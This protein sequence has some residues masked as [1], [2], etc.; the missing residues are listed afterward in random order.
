MCHMNEEQ[1]SEVTS[2]LSEGFELV[3]AEQAPPHDYATLRDEVLKAELRQEIN[4]LQELL[5]KNPDNFEQEFKLR[6][7]LREVDVDAGISINKMPESITNRLYWDIA[8]AVFKPETMFDMLSIIAP[9]IQQHITINIPE[10][11]PA[12]PGAL[13]MQKHLLKGIEPEIVVSKNIQGLNNPPDFEALL[14]YVF[15]DKSVLD[16]KDIAYL[17]LTA[18]ESLKEKLETDYPKLLEALYTHNSALH[19]LSMDIQLFKEQ[20]ITPKDAIE[21]LIKGLLLGGTRMTSS[22]IASKSADTALKRFFNYFK[23]L[24][25]DLQANLRKLSDGQKS[26]GDIIDKYIEKGD[27]VETTASFLKKILDAN[28]DNPLLTTPPVLAPSALKSLL[29]KYRKTRTGALD[30]KKEAVLIQTFPT[31][32]V[33]EVIKRIKPNTLEDLVVLHLNFIPDLYDSIWKHVV[34]ANPEDDLENL[35]T[36]IKEGFFTPEQQEALAKAVATH[37]ARFD[38]NTP[39]MHWAASTHSPLFIN[40]A[41]SAYPESQ[42]LEALKVQNE[43]GQTVLHYVANNPELLKRVLELY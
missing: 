24:D 9:G 20:G 11:K 5:E 27:C 23:A 8:K 15:V 25:K 36:T 28:K 2:V 22:G 42:K 35:A 10:T 40:K 41:L 16:T 14:R 31:P 43:Y 38:L 39:L 19:T 12:E 17:P 26:L 4:F 6:C 32:I 34:L 13:G 33:E 3:A 29:Q 7:K 1:K 21:Q 18:H 30:C 37:Y